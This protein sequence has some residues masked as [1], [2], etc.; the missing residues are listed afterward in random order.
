MRFVLATVVIVGVCIV[1]GAI[2]WWRPGASATSE[3]PQSRHLA[4]CERCQ[5]Y[6]GVD[7]P[8]L[9]AIRAELVER[10]WRTYGR[11]VSPARSRL[12]GESGGR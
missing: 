11:G 5:G 7:C 8:E 10:Y 2:A 9:R 12:P 1:G 6:G 3:G 4:T